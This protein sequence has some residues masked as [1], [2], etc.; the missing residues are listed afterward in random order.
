MAT[1]ERKPYRVMVTGPAKIRP[2]DPQ[3]LRD[4]EHVEKHGYVI[5]EDVFSIAE[6]E[7]A[8]AEIERLRT[9]DASGPKGGRNE[10]EGW[11]TERIYGLLDKSRLFD[12]FVLLERVCA[13]NDWFL[14]PGYMINSFHTIQINPGEDPQELHHDDAYC[15]IPRPRPPLGT[16]I[17]V[18]LDS[19][20]TT[21]GA[22]EI[23]PGSHLWPTGQ[24]PAPSRSQTISATC[25]AGSV[26]Y[27]LG[28]TW[29]GGGKNTSLNPR[30]SLT[31]QYC[32]P[33]IRPTENQILAVDPRKLD[34][35]P[36]SIVQMMGYSPHAPF[37]G[38][39]DGMGPRRGIMR[40]MEW[41]RKDVDFDPPT[42]ADR[43]EG[44]K[45]KL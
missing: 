31:V 11:R 20:T 24:Y 13:L 26:V 16:A 28:T 32:Q 8:K 41:A 2:T 4:I 27:F 10:F 1:A 12:K 6:A 15:Y 38:Y 22:T 23:I 9:K 44:G 19:F 40:L 33:Y 17:I 18:A 35:I 5:L 30:V 39:V 21:N 36:K 29:H 14:D 7:E 3:A 37:I 42:F 45:S 25:P 34:K 43:D